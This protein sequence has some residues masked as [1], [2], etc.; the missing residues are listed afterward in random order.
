M[1][2][3]QLFPGFYAVEGMTESF[4]HS[5]DCEAHS[6]FMFILLRSD[7]LICA[8]P[9]F[10]IC[11]VVTVNYLEVIFGVPHL[12]F[13]LVVQRS[14]QQKMLLPPSICCLFTHFI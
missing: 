12:S 3:M 1:F 5:F 6:F 10:S 7:G 4:L 2:I 11:L 9:C 14:W 8:V 13:K